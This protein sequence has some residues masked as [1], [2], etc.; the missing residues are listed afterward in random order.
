MPYYYYEQPF[1]PWNA[2]GGREQVFLNTRAHEN[3]S[4]VHR[5]FI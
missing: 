3:G 2:K 4:F 5:T 1:L